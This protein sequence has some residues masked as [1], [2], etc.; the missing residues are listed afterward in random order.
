MD[1]VET[2]LFSGLLK[3]G[4]ALLEE[5]VDRSGDGD[6]G[7]QLVDDEQHVV[8]R[9]PEKHGRRYLWIFGELTFQRFVYGT[10]EGQKIEAVPLD[11]QLGLP[12]G[13]FSYVLE[14]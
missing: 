14:D 8:R 1:E 12:N 10:R 5:F 4:G 2:D 11:A 9:L 13:E 6:L 7:E 3:L